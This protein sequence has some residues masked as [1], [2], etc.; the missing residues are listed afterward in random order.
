MYYAG[1]KVFYLFFDQHQGS[2][3][4]PAARQQ[5]STRDP[6]ADVLTEKKSFFMIPEK[7]VKK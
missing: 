3:S 6:A 2:C 4:R 7:G 1:F 5:I